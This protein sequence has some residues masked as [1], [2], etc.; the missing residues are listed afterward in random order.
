MGLHIA[1]SICTK[2]S[3]NQG[4]LRQLIIT[5]TNLPFANAADKKNKGVVKNQD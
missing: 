1:V 4:E 2:M 3:S 5:I